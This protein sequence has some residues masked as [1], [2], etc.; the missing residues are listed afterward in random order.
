[1]KKNFT[2]ILTAILLL[3]FLAFTYV[4]A[5]VI[6]STPN[7]ITL[8]QNQALIYQD[9]V[10]GYQIWFTPTT[11]DLNGTA[12]LNTN[13]AGGTLSVVPSTTGYLKVNSTAPNIYLYFN[14]V[15]IN[16]SLFLYTAG[17]SFV[18]SYTYTAPPPPTPTPTPTTT[19]TTTPTPTP[20]A[21]TETPYPP[22][23]QAP[24][25]SPTPVPSFITPTPAPYRIVGDSN[26]TLYFRGDAYSFSGATGYG[27]YT[28]TS[29][30]THTITATTTG[31]LP[32]P[33]LGF[34]VW[35]VHNSGRTTELTG[36]A[37][38][39]IIDPLGGSNT[40]KWLP[41]ETRISSNQDVIQIKIYILNGTNNWIEKGNFVS[42]PIQSNTL[43]STEWTFNLNSSG[44]WNGSAYILTFSVGGATGSLVTG[45]SF[46]P[47]TYTETLNVKPFWQYLME[48]NL[49]GFL[50]A[51]YLNGFLMED[52]LVGVVCLLFL[53][54]LYIRTKSLLLICI[55]WT[56]LGGF[57]ITAVPALSGLAIVFLILGIAGL[58]YKLVRPN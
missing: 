32:Y 48:G 43:L 53:A 22:P 50:N 40:S 41:M 51:I 26:L 29:T 23:T 19:P 5:D 34:Q 6:T 11:N 13:S 37:P 12:S 17:S 8:K 39:A 24:T 54:P 49:L 2:L 52:I 44:T 57:L 7:L 55:I 36:G 30:D 56:L 47:H 38:T 42:A 4:K 31:P 9:L 21:P 16:A 46:T 27:L 33:V 10:N 35:I 45:L 18:I 1:M 15:Y 58:F 25:A 28:E 3:S 20:A 14:G